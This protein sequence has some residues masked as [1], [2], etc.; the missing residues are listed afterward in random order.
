MVN[1]DTKAI[2]M[3]VCQDY[4]L[5][6]AGSWIIT[7]TNPGFK[8]LGYIRFRPPGRKSQASPLPATSMLA[9]RDHECNITKLQFYSS[10]DSI[11]D[12]KLDQ[13]VNYNVTV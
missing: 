3:R 5:V 12:N 10:T 4:L 7:V 9:C 13:Y 6:L 2:N 1:D 8:I 11:Y